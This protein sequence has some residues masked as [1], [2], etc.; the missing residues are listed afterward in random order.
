MVSIFSNGVPSTLPT[1]VGKVDT[2][3][4]RYLI[5]GIEVV[6]LTSPKIIESIST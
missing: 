6:Y 4:L 5:V 2:Y 3:L 1:L